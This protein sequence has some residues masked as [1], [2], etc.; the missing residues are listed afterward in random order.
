M[1]CARFGV[2]ESLVSDQGSHF[3]NETVKHL[4]ARMQI[5]QAFSPVYSPWVNWAVER[6][7]KDILQV[8]RVLLLEYDIDFHEWPFLLPV[9]QGNLNR[10]PL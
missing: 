1:W 7:N 9:L 3:R 5:E 2:P 4:C 10:I 8:L 6:L